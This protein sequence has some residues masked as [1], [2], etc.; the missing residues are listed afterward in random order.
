MRMRPVFFVLLFIAFIALVIDNW[1]VLVGKLIP[2]RD[3]HRAA[4]VMEQG[5]RLRE[6][7][8]TEEAEA[9]YLEAIQFDPDSPL[10]HAS[11]GILHASRADTALLHWQRAVE[12]SPDDVGYRIWLAKT[13]MDLERKEQA[14]QVLQP[15]LEQT[16]EDNDL[17]ALQEILTRPEATDR[18]PVAPVDR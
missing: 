12:L 11:L 17:R 3:P 8:R 18:V 1:T 16:P 14:L 6:E 7:G 5:H 10:P 2:P 15:A 9:R 13:L 4:Q